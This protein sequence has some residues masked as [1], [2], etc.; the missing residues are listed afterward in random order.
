MNLELE[1]LN[2][3]VEKLRAMLKVAR[4]GIREHINLYNGEYLL[5]EDLLAK[6]EEM[7]KA[8]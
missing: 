1:I 3:K 4:D 5:L 7:E 2:K 8:E 6:L